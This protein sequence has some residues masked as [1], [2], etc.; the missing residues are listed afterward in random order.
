MWHSGASTFFS[1]ITAR[2]LSAML[3]SLVI[4]TKKPPPPAPVRVCPETIKKLLSER[5]SGSQGEVVHFKWQGSSKEFFW[6]GNLRFR[7]FFGGGRGV[8]RGVVE[9]FSKYFLGWLDLKRDFW[10]FKTICRYV[11]VPAYPGFV[12][13]YGIYW[14]VNFCSREILG[15]CWKP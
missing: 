2:I 14:G 3:G 10:V 4:R 7:D 6:V 12:V 5:P 15:F 13:I 11:V 8:E 1:S 9:K